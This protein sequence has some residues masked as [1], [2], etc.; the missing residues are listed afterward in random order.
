MYKIKIRRNAL[1][2]VFLS[3]IILSIILYTQ[4]DIE[5][6]F[7]VD[8]KY[9]LLASICTISILLLKGVRT[10]L[11]SALTI[12]KA[13][14]NNMITIRLGSEFIALISPAYI[15]DELFRIWA[16]NKLGVNIKYSI[17]ISYLDLLMDVL[18]SFIF[19]FVAGIYLIITEVNVILGVIISF[20]ITI[21]LLLHILIVIILVKGEHV[22]NKI[23]GI[24]K[25]YPIINRLSL[26]LDMGIREVKEAKFKGMKDILK[27]IIYALPI[28]I[29]IGVIAGYTL[30]FSFL[31]IGFHTNLIESIF[32]IFISLTLTAIPITIGGAGV[33]EVSI[34]W[35]Y[36]SMFQ[37]AP[38]AGIV[39]YRIVSYY[40]SL[41]ITGL[42][43]S[44][45]IS[46]FIINHHNT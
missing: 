12:D 45:L 19:G 35:Y 26:W 27:I 30:K 1:I 22:L 15:G 2:A 46:K 33:S 16:F 43:L 37:Y 23:R 4:I 42:F 5:E 44:V 25:G 17:W 28:S 11:I 39:I 13:N 34:A 24:I 29:L 32:A 20:L 8:L 3:T 40:I 9:M 36:N 7:R 41:F 14:I 18:S 6:M 21:I 10:Y 31:A 38:W